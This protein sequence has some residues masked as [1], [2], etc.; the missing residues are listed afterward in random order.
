[1]TL[2]S[3]IENELAKLRVRLEFL[4]AAL[5]AGDDEVARAL[6]DDLRRLFDRLALALALGRSAA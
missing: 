4:D 3:Y 5:E 1:M 6:V 2:P